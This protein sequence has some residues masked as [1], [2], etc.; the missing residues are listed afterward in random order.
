MVTGKCLC[1]QVRYNTEAQL[2]GVVACHCSQCRRSSGHHVAAT[3]CRFTELNIEENGAL[4]WFESSPGTWRGFCSNC[5]SNLF[6][7]N[8]AEPNLSIMAGTL[9]GP[10]GLKIAKHIY[11]ADKGDYYSIEPE[12]LG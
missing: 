10:T 1:G 5:G 7:H 11:K 3:Q 6:W 12:P 2:R 8:R 4:R 9:D